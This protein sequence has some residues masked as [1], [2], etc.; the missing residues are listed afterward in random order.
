[1][2]IAVTFVLFLFLALFALWRGFQQMLGE[3][4]LLVQKM[5]AE[6]MRNGLRV[7]QVVPLLV[8]AI[9]IIMFLAIWQD[10]G[11]ERF[12]HLIWVLSLWMVGSLGLFEFLL[13]YRL[14]IAIVRPAV[15]AVILSIPMA[16]FF[17][18]LPR[19]LATFPGVILYLPLAGGI[20]GIGLVW[21]WLA[22]FY[23]VVDR[24]V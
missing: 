4:D 9:G 24:Q 8:V 6:R 2:T 22:K 14:R 20:L 15:A 11:L 1:M 7:L 3:G 10:E 17:T 12:G 16:I 18:P 23:Q 13:P 19:F 21:G 5:G